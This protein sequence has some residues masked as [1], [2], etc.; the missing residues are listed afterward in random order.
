MKR[1]GKI[2]SVV[3]SFSKAP[4]S[5]PRSS[6]GSSA[7]PPVPR[8][9][10]KLPVASGSSVPSKEEVPGAFS[11]R[12]GLSRSADELGSK[13][14]MRELQAEY[15][16]PITSEERKDVLRVEMQKLMAKRMLE[17]KR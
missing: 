6:A 14:G 1:T 12:P 10:K 9:S 15:D 8:L 13:K 11:P 2:P 7:T 3:P 4:P 17:R 16:L 5:A